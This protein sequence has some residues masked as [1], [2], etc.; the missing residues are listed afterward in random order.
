MTSRTKGHLVIVALVLACRST[1][2]A[3]HVPATPAQAAQ[4][5]VFEGMC[6]ASGA[7]PLDDRLFAVADDEDNVLRVFDAERGGPPVHA[8]DVSAGLALPARKKAPEMDLEAAT[9]LGELALWLTSHGRNSKGAPKPERLRLFATTAIAGPHVNIELVG[10][11]CTTLLEQLLVAPSL[12]GLGLGEA[13]LRA[14]KDPGGMN[15]EGMTAAPDGRVLIGFRN[16]V[17]RGRAIVVPLENPYEV[18]RGSPARFGE[19]ILLDLGGWGV[20]GLSYWRGRYVIA[21][22]PVAEQGTPRIYTWSG[23]AGDAPATFLELAAL[24]PEGFFTP[25]RR[26]RILVLSDDGSQMIEG[27]ACK[28]LADAGRKRFRGLWLDLAR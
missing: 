16:P 10:E 2:R 26:D 28:T 8:V 4:T 9:R 24:N 15:I 13:A 25:E 21:A 5:V 7:V 6:D 20:R 14:P 17:P 11:P 27:Q 12:Q 19:P 18:V 1:G 22:G 23:A 3:S